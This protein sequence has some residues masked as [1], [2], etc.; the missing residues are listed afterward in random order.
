MAFEKKQPHIK[1]LEHFD[2]SGKVGRYFAGIA[3]FSMNA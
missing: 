3:S 2:W 1:V